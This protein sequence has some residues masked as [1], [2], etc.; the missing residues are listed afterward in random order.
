MLIHSIELLIVEKTETP[1]ILVFFTHQV[2]C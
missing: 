2:I 1:E